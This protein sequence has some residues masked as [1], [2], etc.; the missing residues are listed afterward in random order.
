MYLLPR[1]GNAEGLSFYRGGTGAPVL[2][3]H[4]VGLRA[5]CWISQIRILRRAYEVFA[6]DM[7]G[8]GESS[9]ISGENMTLLDYSS[10][11]GGFIKNIVKR[12]AVVVG[13]SVGA[14]T[15]LDVAFRFPRWCAGVAALNA[16][17]RRPLEAKN[18]VLSRAKMLQRGD[19]IVNATIERWFGEKPEGRAKR[20]SFLC[21]KWL[22][23]ADRLGYSSLY[24]V[25]ASEDGPA[26]NSLS[27]LEMPALFLT[28]ADD[29]NSTP[30]MSKAMA[31]QA[32]HGRAMIVNGGH[33]TQMSHSRE[34]NR[35]LSEFVSECMEIEQ[36]TEAYGK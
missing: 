21:H 8:H 6:I 29:I 28:G 15:A 11:I 10:R 35:E 31:A 18:A 2:L 22:S 7:P 9:N 23:S 24:R 4:G 19:D 16:I 27:T 20:A 34:V 30:S 14:L 25:F 3:L 13:H 1:V 26:D 36:Q 33:M 12:P 5:E 17:Y 32:P